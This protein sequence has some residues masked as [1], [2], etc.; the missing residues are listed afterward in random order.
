M[1][2]FLP[3]DIQEA[4]RAYFHAATLLKEAG[5]NGPDL[6]D[7]CERMIE[8]YKQIDGT[9]DDAAMLVIATAEQEASDAE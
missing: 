9:W 8:Q 4:V 7:A 6:R 2:S 3:P 5:F 1:T